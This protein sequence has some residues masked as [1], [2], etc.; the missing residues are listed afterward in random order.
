MKAWLL[1][2]LIRLLARTWNLRVHGRLPTGPSIVAFWHG[3]ML[4]AWYAFRAL[5]PVALVSS[6]KDGAL[7]TQLLHDW[8][9]GVVLGSS[10][11]GGKEAL[12]QLIAE[13]SS[14]VVLITPDGPRGPAHQAKPGSVVA[15]HRAHV[16]LILVRVR[17][18][19][20]HIFARSWDKFQL[21]LPFTTIDL[22]IDT[23]WMIAEDATREQLDAHINEMNQRMQSMVSQ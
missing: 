20:A 22:S 15:A 19:R 16:P 17:A 11:K 3:E 21:P 10:S 23:P 4:P 13:A 14:R 1:S 7:L 9:Y 8:G 2:I 18:N 6:S 5:R 12:D